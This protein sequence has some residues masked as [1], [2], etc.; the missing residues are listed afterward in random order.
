M[1]EKMLPETNHVGIY[2][3]GGRFEIKMG[4]LGCV[5]EKN[6]QN[7]FRVLES[8]LN[9][10]KPTFSFCCTFFCSLLMGIMIFVVFYFVNFK[11]NDIEDIICFTIISIAIFLATF[12]LLIFISL[13]QWKIKIQALLEK[14]VN[15]R[16]I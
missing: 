11:S 16:V 1:N 10:I 15:K 12:V 4:E 5:K 3:N 6:I 7:E 9:Q 8:Q 14:F 2:C 13:S